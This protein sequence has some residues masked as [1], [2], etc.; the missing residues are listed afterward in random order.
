MAVWATRKRFTRA[1]IGLHLLGG[2]LNSQR[3]PLSDT[4]S[5]GLQRT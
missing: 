5:R 3:V 4:L 1:M 2:W